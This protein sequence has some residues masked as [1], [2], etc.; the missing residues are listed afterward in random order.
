MEKNAEALN[1]QGILHL[2][3]GDPKSA[4]DVFAAAVAADPAHAQAWYGKGCAHGE[5][6]QY[7][8]A[9]GLK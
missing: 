7:E 5:L 1:E 6:D 8:E 2:Q 9:R 4:V 3:N